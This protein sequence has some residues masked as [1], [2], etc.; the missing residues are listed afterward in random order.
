MDDIHTYGRT[1]G[2]DLLSGFKSMY[3]ERL[4]VRVGENFVDVN[5][6]AAFCFASI[7]KKLV[8]TWEISSDG[9]KFNEDETEGFN[10]NPLNIGD[11]GVSLSDFK[12]LTMLI[13]DEEH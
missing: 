1:T 11:L 8:F 6:R 4:Y 10:E 9:P 7:R 2:Y 5:L 12:I 13:D 3:P